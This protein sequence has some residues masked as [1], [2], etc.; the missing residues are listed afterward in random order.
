MELLLVGV[1]IAVLATVAIPTYRTYLLRS[2]RT[3]GQGVLYDLVSRQE[4]QFLRNG[5]YASEL[6]V[7]MGSDNSNAQHF[8][9][10]RNGHIAK[11]LDGSGTSIYKIELL[12]AS[13][14]SYLLSATAVGDQA[15]DK[16]CEVLTLA[17][18][19]QKNATASRS[20]NASNC[21]R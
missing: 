10:S 17:S 8:F 21:W 9:L 13:T 18:S 5:K 6:P 2:N 16:D 14:T 19:G 11:T 1:M 15:N 3:L 4:L 12:E 20:G 7:L